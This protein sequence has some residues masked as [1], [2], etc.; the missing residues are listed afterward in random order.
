[1]L[2]LRKPR[3]AEKRAWGGNLSD[4]TAMSESGGRRTVCQKAAQPG[5]VPQKLQG[6]GVSGGCG[7]TI[8][9]ERFGSTPLD[10]A[11]TRL[12]ESFVG[13]GFFLF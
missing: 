10:P 8:G 13:P 3:E 4:T 1:M 12:S 7:R 9:S 5:P 2:L 6:H 11:I